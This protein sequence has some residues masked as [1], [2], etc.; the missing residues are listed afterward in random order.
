I[1]LTPTVGV[2]GDEI[3][4]EEHQ[5]AFMVDATSMYHDN[6]LDAETGISTFDV[7]NLPEGC[8]L[9]L[10]LVN[11][12]TDM[13][14]SVPDDSVTEGKIAVNFT[15]G[16][17][18]T[19][20]LNVSGEVAFTDGNTLKFKGSSPLAIDQ[21]ANYGY[22]EYSVESRGINESA[23]FLSGFYHQSTWDD[24]MTFTFSA[25]QAPHY[26]ALGGNAF[27]EIYVGS[28]ELLNGEAFDIANTNLPFSFKIEYLDREN[29]T[30]V[31]VVI[32]NNN[33]AGAT[34]YITFIQNYDTGLYDVSF[35]MFLNNGDITV[36]GY[37]SGELNPRNVIYSNANEGPIAYV[38][39][40]TLD[41][42]GDPCVLYL[43]STRG[44]EAG[45]DQYDIK[46]EVSR[47]EWKYDYLLSFSGSDAAIT[48]DDV[49]YDSAS[50]T[51]TVIGGNWKVS[52]PAPF[53]SSFVAECQ[54]TLFGMGCAYY[55]GEVNIIQ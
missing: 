45:P 48:W 13:Y 39:S 10:T 33:R 21:S 46:C 35:N 38:R 31:P 24:S 49:R 52:T 1:Y 32:D 34:G 22:L 29:Q 41:L 53:G 5:L 40:A 25:S 50:T 6:V 55:Y 12:D 19:F 30:L 2:S 54:T 51:S 4:G 37:Y 16:A 14:V 18:G 36:S 3:F 23:D 43:S 27:V 28:E 11:T 26:L 20:V 8:M 42:S 7:T 9:N 47:S 44:S 15:N 17:G